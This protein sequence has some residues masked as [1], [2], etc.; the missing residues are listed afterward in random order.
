MTPAI[1]PG[2]I[3]YKRVSTVKQGTK[4]VSLSEQ[5]DAISSY[6]ERNSYP[7]DLWLEEMETAAKR[8]RPVFSLAM[9]L[10]RQGKYKG[11][12]LHK[13]DRG[14]RNL[15]DWVDIGDLADQGIEVHFVTESLDLHSRGGR[16]SADI[17]AVVAADF[18]RNQREEIRKGISGRLKQGLYPLPAPIGYLNNG[19]GKMKT[20]DPVM[21]PLV[22]KAF[23]LYATA[24]YSLETLGEEMLRLGLRNRIGARVTRTGLSTLLN[25]PFYIGLIRIKSTGE[26][27]AGIH[28]PLI[29]KALFDRVHQVLTGKVNAKT[30]R[31]A[32]LYRRMLSCA[33]CEY[34]LIGELQKGHV[35]YRCHGKQC[36]ATSIRE[37]LADTEVNRLLQPLQFSDDETAYFKRRIAEL[38]KH[39]AT[40]MEDDRRSMKLQLEQV[41]NR[42]NR[43]TDAYL[44]QALEKTMYE[45]RKTNL[46]LE[47]K[48]IE[49]NLAELTRSGGQG[50]DRIEKFLELAGNAPL[51]HRLASSEEKREM[52]N[53]LTSNRTVDGKKLEFE[54]S[55]PFRDIVNRFETTDGAHKRAI[56]RTWNRLLNT[57]ARLN[58]AD[59]LPDLS[60]VFGCRPEGQ[61]TKS[62]IKEKKRGFAGSGKA[63]TIVPP[64]KK[65]GQSDQTNARIDKCQ[66][67]G[68]RQRRTHVLCGD[69]FQIL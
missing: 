56:P 2:Y 58:S 42:L 67:S 5:H 25:N 65:N 49:E 21:G 51:S 66:L 46:L 50:P 54:P 28:E 57:L 44:E 22:R 15:K 9:K 63:G 23:G 45:E 12:I 4:G 37:E 40:Q 35:Y 1:M 48:T 43:L 33:R 16:L 7:I 17:Q 34:S 10:L 52:I 39:W 8:G 13:L 64:G 31:H 60:G 68:S 20:I 3:A 27:F 47:R 36:Q 6:A 32:F 30:Q 61:D 29:G 18:I 14:A 11:I 26:V 62:E 24:R 41:N 19:K 59:Q 69:E 38:R 55:L 53:I